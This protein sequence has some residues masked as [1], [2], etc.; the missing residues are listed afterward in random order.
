MLLCN[1]TVI[2]LKI[3]AEVHRRCRHNVRFLALGQF[4]PVIAPTTLAIALSF[5]AVTERYVRYI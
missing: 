2:F 3:S 4:M 5:F 1:G